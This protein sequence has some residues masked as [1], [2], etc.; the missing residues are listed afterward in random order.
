MFWNFED[1]PQLGEIIVCDAIAEEVT[2][3]FNELYEARFPI[4]KMKLIEVYEG[5]DLLS[6]GDNNT[7][8]FNYRMI[9]GTNR[10]SNHSF[11][12]AIDINPRQ[13]PYIKGSLI[14]P[15]DSKEFI[16]RSDIKKGMIVKDNP[17][18]NAFLSRG[19]IWGGDWLDK[20][21]YHHFEKYVP[22]INL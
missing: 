1:Q 5:S 21:D 17:C 3:I 6:M 4:E 18:H 20:K 11:G 16:N 7:S 12:L 22:G 14:L 19:W 10:L 8:A 2:E 9:A 13:N 15:E